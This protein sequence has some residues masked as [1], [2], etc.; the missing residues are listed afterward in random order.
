MAAA[1]YLI[2][3]LQTSHAI[4]LIGARIAPGVSLHVKIG[5]RRTHSFIFYDFEAF[6][7]LSK[8]LEVPTD[9]LAQHCTT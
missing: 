4:A 8:F 1:T 9:L 2:P 6:E 7:N 5:N 3:L